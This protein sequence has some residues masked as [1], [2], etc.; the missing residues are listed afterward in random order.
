M[1]EL[2]P[3]KSCKVNPGHLFFDLYSICFPLNE[4]SQ[5]VYLDSGFC[6]YGQLFDP[7]TGR[8]RDVYCQ[9]VNYKYNGTMCVPD[10]NKNA[11]QTQKRM[12]DIDLSLSLTIAPRSHFARG[13]FSKRLNSQMNRTC[14]NDWSGMFHNALHGKYI[15]K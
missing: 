8:C 5:I 2:H 6:Q 9:E 12:S 15:E 13:S 4:G 11:T 1:M 14:T 10:Q 3:F 7:T